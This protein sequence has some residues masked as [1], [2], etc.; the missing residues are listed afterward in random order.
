[1]AGESITANKNARV[2]CAGGW[3]PSGESEAFMK[4]QG[5]GSTKISPDSQDPRGQRDAYASGE[6]PETRAS[7]H[8]SGKRP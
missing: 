8:K 6:C 5:A 3:P 2:P 7:M 4:D 1:M